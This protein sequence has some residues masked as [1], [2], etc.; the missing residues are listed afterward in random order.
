VLLPPDRRLDVL[1]LCSK[2]QPMRTL[3]AHLERAGFGI[4]VAKDLAD[5]R[6]AFF[7]AGGHHCIVVGPDVPPGLV[8]KVIQSLRSVDP[9]LPAVTFGQKVSR[10]TRLR[11]AVLGFHPGSRAGVG[12]LLRFL[13]ALPERA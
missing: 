8:D 13:R 12:A 10:S 3:L 1:A 6:K 9:D 11:T 4:D 5:A 2:R 7:G